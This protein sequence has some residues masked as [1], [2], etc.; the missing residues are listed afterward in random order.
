M[1]TFVGVTYICDG[2]YTFLTLRGVML[3]LEIFTTEVVAFFS[4]F[5]FISG[6]FNK[7]VRPTVIS[8]LFNQED[9]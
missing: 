4:V 8:L 6:E 1:T 2:Y 9:K 5:L 3:S 7:L